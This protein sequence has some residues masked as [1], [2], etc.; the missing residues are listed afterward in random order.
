MKCVRYSMAI[1]IYYL[2]FF[3]YPKDIPD[4]FTDEEL[5]KYFNLTKQEF[6]FINSTDRSMK[7]EKEPKEKE[8]KEKEPTKTKKGGFR[9][10]KKRTRKNKKRTRK[11]KKLY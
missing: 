8:P 9:P 5:C 6:D 4:D 1:S 2:N 11:N 3:P 10:M 7:Q